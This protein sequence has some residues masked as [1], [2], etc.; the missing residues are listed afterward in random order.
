MLRFAHSMWMSVLVLS[1]LVIFCSP[2][3]D[4]AEGKGKKKDKAEESAPVE[5]NC[6]GAI[7]NPAM[8]EWL[9]TNNRSAFSPAYIAASGSHSWYK[10]LESGPIRYGYGMVA[11]A[12]TP[13][14][15]D[16]FMEW[17]KKTMHWVYQDDGKEIAMQML[18]AVPVPGGVEGV[19]KFLEA[20]AKSKPGAP[21]AGK[22]KGKAEPPPCFVSQ[23]QAGTQAFSLFWFV[24]ER[25][26]TV[27]LRLQTP[28]KQKIPTF[29]YAD[30]QELAPK[31][32]GE[33]IELP[34]DIGLHCIMVHADFT[35]EGTHAM[36]LDLEGDGLLMW[37]SSSQKDK[38]C[39]D[40]KKAGKMPI[41]E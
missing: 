36:A 40:M 13:V 27:T 7:D 28:K 38:Y 26:Q 8:Q 37:L 41:K 24:S 11:P 5:V 22:A 18:T 29:L 17:C 16:K 10:R 39:E 14:S 33:A 3:I 32:P 34:W 4:A 20:Q 9:K 15:R 23:Q 1:A 2:L 6:W 19:E 35:A 12:D 30:F 21:A 31:K 25:K